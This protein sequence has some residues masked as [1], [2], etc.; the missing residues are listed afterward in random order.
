MNKEDFE[1]YDLKHHMAMLSIKVH[2]FEKKHR[3]KIKFNG[4]QNASID[5][6]KQTEK[7]NTE[8]RSLERF[9]M[10][11]GLEIALDVGSKGEVVSAD[12]AITAG[13]SVPAGTV[14]AA[15]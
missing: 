9:G 11:A 15:I 1:E 14:A 12:D 10:V 3:R 13:V 5:W 2:R 4:R 6:D 7:G 8:P